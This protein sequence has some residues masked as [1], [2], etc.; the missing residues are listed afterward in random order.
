MAN[1]ASKS[2]RSGDRKAFHG[3]GVCFD[4]FDAAMVGT[5][6]FDLEVGTAIYFTDC[7][8]T[9]RFYADSA[10]KLKGGQPQLLEVTLTLLN[11]KTVDFDGNGIETLAEDIEQAKSEGYDSLICLDFDDGGTSTHYVIFDPMLARID[12]RF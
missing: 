11:P 1:R 2:L 7:L 4:L 3:T 8:D 9:A 5:S 10:A 12:R 6:H